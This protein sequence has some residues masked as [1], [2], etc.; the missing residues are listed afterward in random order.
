LLNRCLELFGGLIGLALPQD[1]HGL[2]IDRDDAGPPALG[3]AVDALAADHGRRAG[4]GGLL[5]LPGGTFTVQAVISPGRHTRIDVQDNGGPWNQ[6]MVDPARHHGLDIVRA[7]AGE[8]GIDGGL[9]PQGHPKILS[10]RSAEK[11]LRDPPLCAEPLPT[12]RA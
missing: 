10:N 7:V 6:A 1:G 4:D 8:W 3:R 11:D 2:V 9:H 5:R 12:Q